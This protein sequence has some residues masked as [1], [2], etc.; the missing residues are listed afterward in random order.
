MNDSR[1]LASVII[2]AKNGEK[3]LFS[4]L[5]A[6]DQQVLEGGYE[7]I[8]ID[9][10]SVDGTLRV[11]AEFAGVRLYRIPPE[12]FGHGRTRNYGASLAQGEFLVYIPQDAT[13]IGRRWLESLLRPFVNPNVAGVYARQ[14]PRPEANAM[15]RFF[16]GE[17]YP[18]EPETKSLD[19]GERPTLARCFFST[20]SGAVRASV[21]A[22]HRFREDII[23][24]EDQAWAA[25][26]MAAGQA[27]AYEPDACV[28]H[29]HQYGI[30]DVFR[31][32][33]DSG[34]SIRQIFSGETGIPFRQVLARL[35]RESAE[36]MRS[37]SMAD[38]LRFV[39]YEVARHAGFALGVHAEWLPLALR[40]KLSSLRYF[41]DTVP[42]KDK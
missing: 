25:Q 20:V 8:V 26:V 10:G 39:P 37:G 34:Y 4:L 14:I 6:L 21:W 40:R 9:S 31:R 33:F 5:K 2:L 1:M 13:P 11:V 36:V 12:D 15:E 18:A 42:E 29:S 19:Q 23:M 38:K 27:I 41:W 32:N 35:G 22:Q 7:V 16:L 28:L 30:V 17:T 3:Y 24:S